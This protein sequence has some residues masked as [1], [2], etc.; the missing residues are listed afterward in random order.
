MDKETKEKMI[1]ESLE[2]HRNVRKEDETKYG[3]ARMCRI[4]K[5][6]GFVYGIHSGGNHCPDKYGNLN[7]EKTKT[8]FKKDKE[9]SIR[10]IA[11]IRLLK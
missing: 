6:C 11:M 1:K 2:F 3:I 4:C 5:N 10:F 9:E 8:K 7:I